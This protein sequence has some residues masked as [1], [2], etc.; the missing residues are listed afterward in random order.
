MAR[1]P[2]DLGPG[3]SK[4][5]RSIGSQFCI[6]LLAA[7]SGSGEDRSRPSRLLTVPNARRPYRAPLETRTDRTPMEART[8]VRAPTRSPAQ[9]PGHNPYAV[10]SASFQQRDA[11]PVGTANAWRDG[12]LLVMR[13]GAALPDRCVKCNEDCDPPKK[14]VRVQWHHWAVYL[15]LL[16]AVPVY[17]VVA[18]LVRKRGEVPAGLCEKH[19]TRRRTGLIL[20]WVGFFAGLVVMLTANGGAGIFVGLAILLLSLIIGPRMARIVWAS[21]IS[22]EYLRI[23]GCSREFL[24]SLPP[25]RG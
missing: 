13:P 15:L 21:H 6:G 14:P 10:S 19:L 1:Q 24:E 11:G 8:P 25:F 20:L 7:P 5:R 23:K 18:L 16:I 22:P 12:K 3:R 2:G 4:R 17:V 9:N